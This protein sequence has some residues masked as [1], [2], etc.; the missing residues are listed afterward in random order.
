M[1]ICCSKCF[2]CLGCL[3]FFL[4]F[5]LGNSLLL[6]PWII[7]NAFRLWYHCSYGFLAFSFHSVP[8]IMECFDDFRGNVFVTLSYNYDFLLLLAGEFFTPMLFTMLSTLLIYFSNSWIVFLALCI[9][10]SEPLCDHWLFLEVKV[11]NYLVIFCFWN[12]G[13]MDL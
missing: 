4:S 11:W 10:L 7:V 1:S 2:L 9:C 6:F 13:V 8:E 12:W 3:F 5:G